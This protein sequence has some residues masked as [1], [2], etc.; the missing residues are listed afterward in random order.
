MADDQ[1]RQI[2]YIKVGMDFTH[3]VTGRILEN[4]EG[5]EREEHLQQMR[6]VMMD[7]VKME[8]EYNCSKDVLAKLK[9][10]LES[11]N[12]DMD[13]DVEKE[14]RDIL[15]RETE[16]KR[17]SDDQVLR[18]DP[19]YRKL[20]HTIQ[21]GG[22]AQED[23]DLAVTDS[24]VTYTDPWSKKLITGECVTNRACG[25]VYDKAVVLKFIEMKK[26]TKCPVV[27]CSNRN[28]ISKAQLFTDPDIQKKVNKQRKK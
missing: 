2:K 1:D 14:F 27:G 23:D 3:M 21:S 13:R 28:P 16:G 24:E 10:G 4:L 12:A 8:A 18:S 17:L 20:E 7:Y 26:T 6:R 19:R 9:K 15:K 25:H 22:K 5:P 11:E